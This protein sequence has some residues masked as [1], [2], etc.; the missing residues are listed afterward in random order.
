MN[1]LWSGTSRQETGMKAG[2][3]RLGST[4]DDLANDWGKRAGV[5]AGKIMREWNRCAGG[6]E[7]Q[8]TGFGGSTLRATTR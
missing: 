5:Y 7:D 3:L 1:R 8:V 6:L 4:L 2:E